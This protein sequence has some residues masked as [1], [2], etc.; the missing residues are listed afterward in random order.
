MNRR[1]RIGTVATALIAGIVALTSPT[2]AQ[3]GAGRG[4]GPHGFERGGMRA[5]PFDSLNLTAD[6]QSRIQAIRQ[7][8]ESQTASLRQQAQT[9][10]EQMRTARQNNDQATI[11]SLRQQEQTL[12][13]QMSTYQQ[14]MRSQIEQVLTAEQKARLEAMRQ[15]HG[16]GE[17]G[18]RG[19]RR[20]GHCDGDGG[21][22]KGGRGE[23]MRMNGAQGNGHLRTAPG[24]T[25]LR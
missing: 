25:D 20:G 10:R 23:G 11:A 15:Q 9:L 16:K 24:G 2:F 18:G 13:Q 21:G 3:D 1:T 8:F 22:Q 5:N 6:Q 19:G 12:R 14:Q 17:M 7:Q 4:H